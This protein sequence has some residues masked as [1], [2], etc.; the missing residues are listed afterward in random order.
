MAE[1]GRAVKR[2]RAA[3]GGARPVWAN[4]RI[5]AQTY[6]D[7][8]L[9]VLDSL[10]RLNEGQRGYIRDALTEAFLAGE[11]QGECRAIR[12]MAI[13]RATTDSAETVRALSAALKVLTGEE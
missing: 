7:E 10:V 12:I 4:T 6:A 2:R 9:A 1:W 5:S 3:P 8:A 13:A 11:H